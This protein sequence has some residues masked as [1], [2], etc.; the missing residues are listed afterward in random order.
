MASGRQAG[1]LGHV[2]ERRH[3]VL[4]AAVE[5]QPDGHGLAPGRGVVLAEDDVE[6]A[7]AVD[8][9]EADAADHVVAA[10]LAR[11]LVGEQLARA[12]HLAEL[13]LAVV[14]EQRR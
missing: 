7:V 4:D 14:E 12:G 13:A 9:A 3:A 5:V 8:V 10:G 1:L 11:A 2:L 6:Q